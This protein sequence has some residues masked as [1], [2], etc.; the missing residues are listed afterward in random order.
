MR[1]GQ[2]K[3]K[4]KDLNKQTYKLSSFIQNIRQYQPIG[5]SW[6][7]TAILHYIWLAQA[8]S[9][10]NNNNNNN[11]NKVYFRFQMVRYSSQHLKRPIKCAQ[12]R[13]LGPVPIV[14]QSQFY[15]V[16]KLLLN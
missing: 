3:S 1:V 10:K 12:Y 11:N 7:I 6:L 13:L 15:I 8:N 5:Y 16:L 9:I 14:H 4:E 2:V